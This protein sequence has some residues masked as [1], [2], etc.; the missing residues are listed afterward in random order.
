MRM[1]TAAIPKTT[2]TMPPTE[3]PLGAGEA[4]SSPAR[5]DESGEESRDGV[6]GAE[7][8]RTNA[9][10]VMDCPSDPVVTMVVV[11]PISDSLRGSMEIGKD[12]D[13]GVDASVVN[14]SAGGE[15]VDTSESGVVA[16]DDVWG[17]A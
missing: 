17:A 8:D 16:L 10:R 2:P 13:S 4:L 6:T 11:L 14:A 5:L 15:V 1:M 9:V 3:I 12:D 7:V